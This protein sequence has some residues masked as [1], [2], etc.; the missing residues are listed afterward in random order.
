VKTSDF[1]DETL[2]RLMARSQTDALSELYDRY[3]RLVFSVAFQTLGSRELAEEVTQAF[4]SGS[5]LLTT[6]Y[7]S[8]P[9]WPAFLPPRH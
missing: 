4:F 6:A 9:G 8:P 2:L 3:S 1:N 7:K 5:M